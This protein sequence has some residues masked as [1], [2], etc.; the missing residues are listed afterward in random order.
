MRFISHPC[1]WC[2][3]HNRNLIDFF[4]GFW[5]NPSL[6]LTFTVY[7]FKGQKE[8]RIKWVRRLWKLKGEEKKSCGTIMLNSAWVFKGEEVNSCL[9]RFFKKT[10]KKRC[11]RLR[12]FVCDKV[13]FLPLPLKRKQSPA[14]FSNGNARWGTWTHTH[15]QHVCRCLSYTCMINYDQT[16]NYILFFGLLM[17]KCKS[18]NLRPLRSTSCFV[19]KAGSC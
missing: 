12:R 2:N 6:V 1:R 8:I 14:V 7:R 10:I 19:P 5:Y 4:S 3:S 11:N 15:T 18:L 13:R 16:A 9:H 17:H